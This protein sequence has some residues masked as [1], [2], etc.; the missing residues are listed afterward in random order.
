[1][2][3]VLGLLTVQRTVPQV[4]EDEVHVGAAGQHRHARL[5]D[6]VTRQPFGQDLRT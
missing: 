3:E 1:M 6:I 2:Q 4:D 5:G